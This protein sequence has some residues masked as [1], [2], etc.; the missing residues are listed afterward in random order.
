MFNFRDRLKLKQKQKED[1]E[2]INDITDVKSIE[3]NIIPLTPAD[4]Q[5]TDIRITDKFENSNDTGNL[6]NIDTLSNEISHP[7][8][9][10]V[11]DKKTD[12]RVADDE[13]SKNSL[14]DS[15]DTEMK[16]VTD[17]QN[18]DIHVTGVTNLSN[19]YTDKCNNITNKSDSDDENE[20][21]I[22]IEILENENISSTGK[23]KY[24]KT[25]I[26]LNPTQKNSTGNL[27]SSIN[28][29]KIPLHNNKISPAVSIEKMSNKDVPPLSPSSPASPISE[30]NIP[31]NIP[32]PTA[33]ESYVSSEKSYIAEKGHENDNIDRLAIQKNQKSSSYSSDDIIRRDYDV[34]SDDDIDLDTPRSLNLNSPPPPPA[35]LPIRNKINTNKEQMDIINNYKNSNNKNNDNNNI[36]SNNNNNTKK[37]NNDTDQK[38]FY[39]EKINDVPT[40]VVKTASGMKKCI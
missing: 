22:D 14:S 13:L 31:H 18:T 9:L 17:I 11:N 24:E 29:L 16:K 34:D 1:K 33:E 8:D 21:E 10:S 32:T 26:P 23:F 2:C 28:T 20:D 39:T 40:P 12:I 30:G 5:N 7:I 38:V 6:K 35:P 15:Q 37:T 27:L 25:P 19:S 3:N 4:K 36:S